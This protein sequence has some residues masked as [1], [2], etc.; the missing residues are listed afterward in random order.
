MPD[1]SGKLLHWYHKNKRDLPWRNTRNPYLVWL[2]EIILQQTRVDQGLPYYLRFAENYPTVIHL[3][4]ADEKEVMKLW[5]GLGYYSRA[6]NLHAAA[7]YIAN[8]LKGVFPKNYNEILKLKGVGPYTAGAISSFA[9]GEAQ[10]VVDGNVYRVLARY[11][12]IKTPIDSPKGQK[13]F[14][15][16][17]K[18]VLD[19][20]DPG[21]HNQAIME[22]G[23]RQCVP[24]NP[25]CAHCPLNDSCFAFAKKKVKLLPLKAG[26]TKVRDRHFYYLVIRNKK[27]VLLHHRKGKDIWHG[28]FDFPLIEMDKR[29]S[30]EKIIAGKELKQFTGKNAFVVRTVSPVMKHVLSHQHIYATFIEIETKSAVKDKR[31]IPVNEKDLEQYAI[32]RLIDR[33]LRSK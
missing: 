32:P 13:E 1:L 4:R 6:R 31:F 19:K 21:T 23:A 29:I 17:A 2:S 30:A 5:Q 28:L 22:F 11:F 10:P 3:A 15:S 33:Y 12:G 20:K 27:K 16:L 18:E 8:E 26:K 24:Q 7:K 9:F 25:D 14:L